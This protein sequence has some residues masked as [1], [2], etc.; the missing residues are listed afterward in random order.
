MSCK[1]TS[2]GLL[3]VVSLLMGGCAES[4]VRPIA[5]DMAR[6]M[7]QVFRL[8]GRIGVRYDGQGYFG[9]LHWR[10]AAGNDEILLLSPLGQAV[11][12]IEHDEAGVRLEMSGHNYRAPD[13]SALTEQ[14]L[15]WR[16]PLEG[17]HY[18]IVGV[19]Q[20]GSAATVERDEA[21]NVIRLQQQGWNIEYRDYRQEGPY[22]LPSRLLLHH[23]SVELKLVVDSWELQP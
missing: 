13:A 15:G 19:P 5:P 21:M 22:L 17:L 8:E 7:P 18:W 20:P 4:P 3:L 16:L 1:S 14:V 2:K 9:N 23:A 11:A 12:K 10:H 6:G